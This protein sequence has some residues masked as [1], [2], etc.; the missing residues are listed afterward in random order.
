MKIFFEDSLPFL[1]AGTKKQV[2]GCRG[3]Y[4]VLK[5]TFASYL[6]E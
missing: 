4:L 3:V 6:H 5:Y 2:N 1:A